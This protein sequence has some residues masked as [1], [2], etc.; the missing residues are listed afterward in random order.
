M[1]VNGRPVEQKVRGSA[2]GGA[3]CSRK[4]RHRQQPV[5]T[6]S[7]GRMP[8]ILMLGCRRRPTFPP[9]MTLRRA[10]SGAI[11][12]TAPVTGNIRLPAADR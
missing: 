5:F 11:V 10:V 3:L 9:S 7:A 1:R 2:P 4:G 6:N 12:H 8:T